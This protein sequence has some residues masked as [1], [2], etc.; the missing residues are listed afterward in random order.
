MR[1]Y[2]WRKHLVKSNN[3]VKD[4]PALP[5]LVDSDKIVDKIKEARFKALQIL[6]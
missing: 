1:D 4:N 3:L 5:D 2:F 6:I